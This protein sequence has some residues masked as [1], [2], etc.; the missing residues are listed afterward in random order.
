MFLKVYLVYLGSHKTTE[1]DLS[2]SAGMSSAAAFLAGVE[3]PVF[4]V[5]GTV[6]DWR[7][8]FIKQ[9]TE[10]GTKYSIGRS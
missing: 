5:F 3:A 8:N 1:H 4:D 6:A 9:L 10:I 2:K 7:K